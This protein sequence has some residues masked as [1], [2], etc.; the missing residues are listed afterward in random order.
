[1]TVLAWSPPTRGPRYGRQGRP[2]SGGASL[3]I[4]LLVGLC[5]VA[6]TARPAAGPPAT[7]P[8]SQPR[9]AHSAAD[10]G[11]CD[12]GATPDP[13]VSL[14][15]SAPG[16]SASAGVF[17]AID[18]GYFRALG[19]D[20]R[21]T[22]VGGGLE[23]LPALAANQIDIGAAAPSAGLFNALARDVPVKILAEQDS[24]VPGRK[25]VYALVVRKDLWDSGVV[26]DYPDLHGR[27]VAA[28][29]VG[30]G[31][32]FEMAMRRVLDR[33]SLTPNEVEVVNLPFADIN[34]ALATR[35]IDAAIDIEPFLTQ[36]LEQGLAQVWLE[37]DQIWEG[38]ALGSVI[39]GSPK[40]VAQPAVATRFLLGYLRGVR[41]YLDA[42]W[43]DRGDPAAV[44][45]SLARYTGVT[46]LG[47][48]ARMR[49][50]WIN[51][52]GHVDLDSIARRIE[53]NARAGYIREPLD[54][55]RVVDNRFADCAAR[56]LGAYPLP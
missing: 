43:F 53:L 27:K 38:P 50:V 47:L 44:L 12:L 25:T 14:T 9:P 2:C 34:P 29:G 31:S 18:R 21:F 13:P 11:A 48:W 39:M 8:S 30:G 49:P 45:P 33:G 32:T 26:R 51:P 1:M 24:S 23:L 40:L 37:A 46:D 19:L 6:C 15:F 4:V 36:A 10:S 55:Q 28:T 52:A 7:D 5:L 17:V 41:D 42:L 22:L 56:L 54:P 20:V 3:A 16:S 35:A